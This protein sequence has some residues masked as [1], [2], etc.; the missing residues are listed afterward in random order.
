MS[1]IAVILLVNFAPNIFALNLLCW[2]YS[3]FNSS[4]GPSKGF[5]V[6]WFFL[7]WRIYTKR[8]KCNLLSWKWFKHTYSM[9]NF[10]YSR[11][12]KWI[13]F[14]PKSTS[15]L[16][17]RFTKKNLSLTLPVKNERT[18][19]HTM[20]LLLLRIQYDYHHLQTYEHKMTSIN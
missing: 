11:C 9:V 1:V 13:P 8:L 3:L 2:L 6:V 20:S 15:K 16:S 18:E 7:C 14:N 5:C 4:F 17:K 10:W 19:Y 12:W